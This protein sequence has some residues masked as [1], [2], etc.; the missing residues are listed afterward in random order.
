MAVS[1][2]PGAALPRLAA[3]ITGALEAMAVNPPAGPRFVRVE[4]PIVTLPPLEWLAAQPDFTQYYWSDRE[5]ALE[6]A[7]VGEAAVMEPGAD[8]AGTADLSGLFARLRAPIPAGRYAVRWYGGFRFCSRPREHTRWEAFR[9]YRF[10]VPRFEVTRAEGETKLACNLLV[11]GSPG[12]RLTRDAVLEFLDKLAFPEAAPPDDLPRITSRVEFPARVGWDSAVAAALAAFAPGKL[13]KVVLARETCF[14]GE[15]PVD[16]VALLRRLMRRTVRSF[17]FC[18]HP[19]ADRAFIGAS[20]ERLYRRVNCF[21]ETEAVAGTRPRG[22]TDAEDA[23]QAHA[24]MH[25]R[26]DYE[27]HRHVVRGILKDIEPLSRYTLSEAHPSIMRLRNCQH[28]CTRLESI[29]EDP[30]VDAQLI[31][32][33]HPTPAVGGV[34]REA[35][36][37]WIA[38][39]E[40]FDRGIYAAPVGWVGYD[41]AEFCVAIRSALVRE[42]TVAVY[43]G[44]GIVPGSTPEAEWAEIENKMGNFLSALMDE[45]H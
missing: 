26:K 19:V 33:M 31:A 34:P 3:L 5:G 35:A 21:L 10:V 20:P 37:E 39:H 38:R 16:P 22:R 2:D 13:E 36:L 6:M 28:L 30:D 12:D 8:E 44:A 27:E 43:T 25:S 17:D 24:L 9:D 41:A 18:F 23:E 7:G 11:T 14:R 45:P 42:E 4:T 15:H 29:L 1:K 40:P 32:A